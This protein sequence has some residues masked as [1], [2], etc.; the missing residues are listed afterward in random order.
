MTIDGFNKIT[1][2]RV[3]KYISDYG[4]FVTK[5][6]G[7][8][9]NYYTGVDTKPDIIAF[10]SLEDLIKRSKIIDEAIMINSRRFIG[11]EYWNLV[12]SLD[13]IKTSLQTAD[14]TSRWV[15]STI[16]RGDFNTNAEVDI[17]LDQDKTI[18]DLAE[19]SG[20]IDSDN[21]WVKIALRN[22]LDEEDYTL[23]GG[24]VLKINMLGRAAIIIDDVI[25]ETSG[26]NM[27]GK[28][29]KAVMTYVDDDLETVIGEACMN[30]CY[31]TLI[32]LSKG[33]IPEFREMGMGKL[34]GGNM[35]SFSYP[36]ILRQLH[37]TFYRD[38]S[39]ESVSISE[40]R[41]E[42]DIVNMD[43]IIESKFGKFLR[44][45]ISV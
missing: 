16:A 32:K 38:S 45:G 34:V 28:D 33:D 43:V 35:A 30:Q 44:E 13:D 40:F 42:E 31:E 24:N 22:D 3:D 37:R 18:E 20:Y 4:V 1:G 19:E 2:I 25:D 29:I 7:S 8:I 23:E 36:T 41:I 17:V 39:V 6:L 15:R 12:E 11:A 27:Y 10:K 21:S 14:N 9:V 5:N 26:D